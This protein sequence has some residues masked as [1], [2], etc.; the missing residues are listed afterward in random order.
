MQDDGNLV[1]YNRDNY[2]FWASE[3]ANKGT[4]G[5]YRLIIDEDNCNIYD[6]IGTKIW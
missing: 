6:K 4:R 2:P 5:F 3:T 1:L